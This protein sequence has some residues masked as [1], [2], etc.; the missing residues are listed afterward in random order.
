MLK[1]ILTLAAGTALGLLLAAGALRVTGAW[2]LWP[3][4]ELNRSA[5]YVREVLKLVNENYVDATAVGYDKLAHEAIHGV[6]SSLDPHSEFLAAN[7]FGE[8][9]DDLDGD[10]CGIGVQVELRGEKIVI[11]APMAGTPAERAGILRGDEIVSVD[12]RPVGVK[13]PMDD[14]I[15]WL[16][17]KPHS[18]VVVGIHRPDPDKQM[19]F[20]LM[21]EVI[22]VDSVREVQ[23]IEDHIGYIHLVDFSAHTGEQFLAA[24]DGLLHEGADALIIDMRNNPGGL[25]EAAVEVTEPFFKKGELVVYTEGRNA[26]DREDLLAEMAGEPVQVPIAVLINA[27]T[28]SAAEIVTGALKDTHRAVIV[29]E[30]SFGKGSVQTIFKLRNGEGMRITTARYFTPGGISIHGKGI[31]PNV[32]VIMT[33]EEDNKLRL[34]RMRND[35]TNAA[36]FKERFGFSPIEDRQLQAA[37]DVLKGVT[38]LQTQAGPSG[39][40]Q[41]P[42]P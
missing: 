31:A 38:L 13:A 16:R 18:Q 1:R 4:R 33:P 26:A 5:D 3:N 41:P 10:F 36:D 14:A 25:L 2:G 11:I 27:G 35:V 20:T 40:R 8:F 21:R 39:T 22:K 12:G 19:E 24:L 17:G 6:V 37:I 9:E 32:E 23:L 42:R 7:E 15:K 29:G 28:A 30:R 34:Q